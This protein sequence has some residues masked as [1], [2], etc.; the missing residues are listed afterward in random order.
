MNDKIKQ[1]GYKN[2]EYVNVLPRYLDPPKK[3]EFHKQAPIE[4]QLA[5]NDLNFKNGERMFPDINQSSS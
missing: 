1:G 2:E 5:N 4:S 3:S